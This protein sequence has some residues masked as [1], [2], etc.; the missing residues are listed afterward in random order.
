M[1]QGA[2]ERCLRQNRFKDMKLCLR[3]YCTGKTVFAG[4]YPS[5][6]ANGYAVDVCLGRRPDFAGR[7]AADPIY[8]LNDLEA[9]RR[10]QFVHEDWVDACEYGRTRRYVPCSRPG[11]Y[12]TLGASQG[13]LS[14]CAPRAR[15]AQSNPSV[16]LLSQLSEEEL[17]RSCQLSGGGPRP[18]RTTPRKHVAGARSGR[19]T[20][21]PPRARA[22]P[23]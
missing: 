17:A 11:T 4:H 1:E 6:A 14:R 20:G 15:T 2:Y 16:K 10:R 9:S 18:L 7:L 12:R 23:T 21:R 13:K 22:V 5:P 19:Q 8:S 3:G